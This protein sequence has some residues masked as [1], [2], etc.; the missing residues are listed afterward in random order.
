[1]NH[2]KSNRPDVIVDNEG[3]EWDQNTITGSQLRV[4]ASLPSDVEIFHKVPGH[5]DQEVKDNT[6]VDL[7]LQKGPNRFSTQPVGS[8][9][10]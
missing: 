9:A 4:L 3:Y 8:Q 1:M 7:T 10:G 5:P 6:V 2:E